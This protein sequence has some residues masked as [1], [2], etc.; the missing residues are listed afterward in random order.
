MRIIEQISKFCNREK[1]QIFFFPFFDYFLVV[2]AI[3]KRQ[4]QEIQIPHSMVLYKNKYRYYHRDKDG[5][6]EYVI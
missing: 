5:L 2:S 6:S 4:F 3:Y 1:Q